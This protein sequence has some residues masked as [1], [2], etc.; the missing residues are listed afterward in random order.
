MQ[1]FPLIEYKLRA[2]AH[3][4]LRSRGNGKVRAR[5]GL[6]RYVIA[7]PRGELC[8]SV[9]FDV[10]RQVRLRV[11]DIRKVNSAFGQVAFLAVVDYHGFWIVARVNHSRFGLVAR[12]DHSRFGL[13]ARVD[14]CRFGLLGECAHIKHHRRRSKHRKRSAYEF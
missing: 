5:G 11:L 12:V 8:F 1:H 10:V 7:F 9:P 4:Q 14:N 3:K 13:V 6:F 2:L